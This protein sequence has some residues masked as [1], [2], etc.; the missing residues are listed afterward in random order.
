MLATASFNHI[1]HQIQTSCLN[2][3]LQITPF[4][5]SIQIK[6]S[7]VKNRDGQPIFSVNS[8]SYDFHD[9]P[10]DNTENQLSQELDGLKT[11]QKEYVLELAAVYKTIDE[12]KN[13]INERD[14]LIKEITH[15]D[16]KLLLQLK[17]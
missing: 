10:C 4:S 1:L 7:L 5:A 2:Y 11:K 17:L 13:A 3:Q 14:I 12:L 6:K 8:N 9:L 15:K 16:N